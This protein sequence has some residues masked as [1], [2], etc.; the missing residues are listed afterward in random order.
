VEL[1]EGVRRLWRLLDL[2]APTYLVGGCLRDA[3]LGAPPKDF[4]LAT[5]LSP[6]QVTEAAAGLHVI[7]TGIRFGTVTVM[8]PEP[9]E[10]TTLRA[11]GRYSDRRHPDAVRYTDRVEED[12]ARRDFTVNA[13]AMG[14]G[15]ALVDPFDGQGDLR[16]RIIRAVGDPADRFLEDPL[17]IWR[18]VRFLSQLEDRTLRPWRLE[19]ATAA[20]IERYRAETV[21]VSEERV[22]D[23]LLKLL[24]CE[25]LTGLAAAVRTRLLFIAVPELAALSG[26]AQRHPQHDSD[27]LVHTLR[28]VGEVAG[29]P[30]LRLA[31]LL[32][33]I[34]KPQCVL[35]MDGV[36]HFYGHEKLGAR[37]ADG[38][39][40]RLRLPGETV[41]R[42]VALVAHHMF[43]W[44]EAGPKG[45]RRL[46]AEVGADGLRDLVAL[47]VA[48]VR[49]S[50]A[51]TCGWTLPRD[52]TARVEAVLAEAD[53]PER[54][55][56]AVNG[57]DIMA[58]F[59][60]APGPEVGRLLAL[61]QDWVWEDLARN[62][63][64]A[65]LE[66]LRGAVGVER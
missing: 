24:V 2:R 16:R 45:Y 64:A 39:L 33:D 46:M 23:E 11:D 9:V 43:P 58:E 34:A 57:R 14:Y 1:P 10:V 40:R 55:R 26:F 36:T 15:G 20:A 59:G 4:D 42:V 19:P 49:G 54:T 7:P 35:Y 62:E 50:R 56:L 25:S 3:L 5:A 66:H 6:E 30:V 8:A 53:T 27:V 17:R 48:D 38:I 37:M 52:V 13:M 63:R 44:S 32:H 12:L 28:V 47:H 51:A 31:A 21:E 18:A 41:E 60:L 29:T 22:R 61:A 65:I